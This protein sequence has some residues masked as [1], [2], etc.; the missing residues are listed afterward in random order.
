MYPKKITE[1]LRYEYGDSLSTF[2]SSPIDALHK[3]DATENDCILLQYRSKKLFVNCEMYDQYRHCCYN[4]QSFH[5]RD[6]FPT[7]FQDAFAVDYSIVD[8][9]W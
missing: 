8:L 7:K 9:Q 4:S 6:N 1:A 3:E 2:A 5:N